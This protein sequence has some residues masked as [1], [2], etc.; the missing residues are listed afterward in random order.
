MDNVKNDAEACKRTDF[1]MCISRHIPVE[2]LAD[3]PCK[4]VDTGSD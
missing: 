1:Q 2:F 3:G 4:P